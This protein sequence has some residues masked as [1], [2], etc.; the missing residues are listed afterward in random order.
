MEKIENIFQQLDVFNRHSLEYIS[1]QFI[2][3]NPNREI[4]GIKEDK[5][6]FHNS[7]NIISNNELLYLIR[8]NMMYNKKKY[9]LNSLFQY[10]F[11]DEPDEIL[12]IQNS[13]TKI[14][15]LS[16][17]NNIKLSNTISIMQ[18]INC[19]YFILKR[20]K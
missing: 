2:Y 1:L 3:I 11:T 14:I 4:E 19:I 13:N 8:R 18:D 7:D 20:E 17:I 10:N 6:F 9:Y 16:P 5:H 12:D 15:S